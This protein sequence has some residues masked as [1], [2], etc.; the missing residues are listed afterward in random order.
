MESL[1]CGLLSSWFI[2]TDTFVISTG[3]TEC[4]AQGALF[5]DVAID[6][7]VMRKWEPPN[8]SVGPVNPYT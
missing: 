7:T 3:S 5:V 1:T 2:C 4:I 6:P 8:D